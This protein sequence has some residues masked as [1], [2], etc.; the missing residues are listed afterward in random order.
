MICILICTSIFYDTLLLMKI[1]N[2][3]I[4]NFQ[5]PASNAIRIII[6]IQLNTLF[7]L[8]HHLLLLLQLLLLCI[9]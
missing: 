3:A 9:R 4:I 2:L 5:K 7:F 6:Q 8:L 1:N